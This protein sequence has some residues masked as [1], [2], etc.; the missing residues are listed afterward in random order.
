MARIVLNKKERYFLSDKFYQ[1]V[2]GSL[3]AYDIFEN[4]KSLPKEA[5]FKKGEII[6]NFFQC[7]PT[8]NLPLPLPENEVEVIAMEDNTVIEEFR[9]EA[10]NIATNLGLSKIFTQLLKENIFKLFYHL[11]DKKGYFLAI[12]RFYANEKGTLLREQIH[13]E[14]FL[15]S[16][17]KFYSIYTEL[18]K[19]KYL[20]EIDRY[21][22][23]NLK[24]IDEYFTNNLSEV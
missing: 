7:L 5:C 12:L 2:S 16:K 14:N 22:Q 19:E 6:G 18:K 11:Y 10:K 20:K 3:C 9:F 15:M 8:E 4:G 17:S 13:Y 21:I 23:L 24:K 1:V